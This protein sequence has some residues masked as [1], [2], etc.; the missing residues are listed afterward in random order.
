MKPALLSIA[1]VY[2]LLAVF[3]VASAFMPKTEPNPEL[4]MARKAK[5][6]A[7]TCG[8]Q[9]IRPSLKD[10]DSFRQV[11]YSYKVTDTRLKVLVD[12]TATNGFG[13]RVR[14][15]KVCIYTL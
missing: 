4:E 8:L 10:P 13:G 6:A 14:G 5:L 7:Y 11:D 15:Q 9:R 3:G 1:A 12:Y 2:G